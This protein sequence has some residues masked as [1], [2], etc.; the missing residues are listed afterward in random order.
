M[1]NKLPYLNLG[2]GQRYHLEWRNIDFIAHNKFVVAHNLL[3]GIPFA[4]ETFEVV[5][6]S[7]LLEHFSKKDALK[8]MK[9]CFRVLKKGGTLRVAVPDLEQIAKEYLK[10]LSL[11]LQG[12][13]EG[14][15]N[16]EWILLEMYDQAVRTESG[17]EMAKYIYQ[18]CI[19]NEAYIYKRLGEEARVLRQSYLNN[20]QKQSIVQPSNVNFRLLP[21]MR[22]LIMNIKKFLEKLIS[23]PRKGWTDQINVES[24]LGRF[25]LSGEIHQWM[26][27][28]HSLAQLLKKIGFDEIE[29]KDATSS[30][31]SE[32]NTYEL[33]SKNGM[34]FKPDSLFMEAI[35]P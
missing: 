16:Y 18:E 3:N 17:G 28:R 14:S 1:K 9:E 4:D 10:N 32:W 30:R 29:V 19:P 2:C 11:A 13:R 6:H 20:I 5:Y 27:D 34:I 12:D 23:M 35:K 15:Q 25:R 8:F 21:T 26:Y 31:I 24:Q 7:H 22:N 33:E